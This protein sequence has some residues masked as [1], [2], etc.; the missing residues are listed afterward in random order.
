MEFLDELSDYQV[1]LLSVVGRRHAGIID[2]NLLVAERPGSGVS[3]LRRPTGGRYIEL[4]SY[5]GVKCSTSNGA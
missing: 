4:T 2:T 1:P 3:G 5:R